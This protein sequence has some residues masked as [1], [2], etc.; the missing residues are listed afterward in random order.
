MSFSEPR[1]SDW[2]KDGVGIS[3]DGHVMLRSGAVGENQEI[4]WGYT[5]QFIIS[6]LDRIGVLEAQI[7]ILTQE[8]NRKDPSRFIE[9]AIAEMEKRGAEASGMRGDGAAG[10]IMWGQAQAYRDCVSYVKSFIK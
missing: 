6:E 7:R 8:A 5:K 1:N 2:V 4:C 10:K 9:E 3:E